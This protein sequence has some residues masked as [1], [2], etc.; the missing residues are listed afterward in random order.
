MSMLTELSRTIIN[1]QDFEPPILNSLPPPQ[2]YNQLAAS[3]TFPSSLNSNPPAV[4][5]SSTGNMAISAY[6]KGPTNDVVEFQTFHFVNGTWTL[7][8]TTIAALTNSQQL[9]MSLS[10]NDD[11]LAIGNGIVGEVVVYALSAAGNAW[12]QVGATLTSALPA[13]GALLQINNGSIARLPQ[14]LS[15]LANTSI[16]FYTVTASA[17]T[18]SGTLTLPPIAGGFQNFVISTDFSTLAIANNYIN[19]NVGQVTVLSRAGYLPVSSWPIQQV[20]NPIGV[21]S[22]NVYMGTGL[23][24]SSDGN[25]LAV[26]C[27]GDGLNAPASVTTTGAVLIYN[28]NDQ[29]KRYVQGQK[30]IPLDYSPA[31]TV[32]LNFGSAMQLNFDGNTLVATGWY[33]NN[34]VGATW[35]FVLTDSGIWIQNGN[36]LNDAD[37][38]DGVLFNEGLNVAIA[39]GNASVIVSAIIQHK[40]PTGLS[41]VNAIVVY[42]SPASLLL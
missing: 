18:L 25:V 10:E 36:K 31:S 21:S 16:L 11:L 5:V 23:A 39:R 40:L 9:S 28:Y 24:I 41:I 32:A 29:T 3:I 7:S 20:L 15:V 17:L 38:P 27:P 4:V 2:S 12:N 34:Q 13:F 6:Q 22:A 19:A 30:I 33:D 42:Q 37:A 26:G 35:V 8:I 1:A 14:T